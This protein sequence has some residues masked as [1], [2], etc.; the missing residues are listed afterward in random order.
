MILPDVR[1]AALNEVTFALRDELRDDSPLVRQLAENMI[2]IAVQK[3]IPIE[4]LLL[5]I[6]MPATN[7]QWTAAE[8]RRFCELLLT[9]RPTSRYSE[10]SPSSGA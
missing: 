8:W 6:H 5:W 10:I 9:E 1:E 7:K 3:S 2:A 4:T